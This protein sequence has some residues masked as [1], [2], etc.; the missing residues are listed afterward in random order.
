MKNIKKTGWCGHPLPSFKFFT[1]AHLL[2]VSWPFSGSPG[3]T[4]CPLSSMLTMDSTLQQ[5][6]LPGA[7]QGSFSA[8]IQNAGISE[9]W[10]ER[11]GNLK[12]AYHKQASAWMSLEDLLGTS[13]S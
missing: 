3:S 5:P 9:I 2:I 11:T 4:I 7:Q 12:R 8:I 10:P 1:A 6:I 13:T